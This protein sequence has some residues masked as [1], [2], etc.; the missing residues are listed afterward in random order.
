[1]DRPFRFS[2][3]DPR[4]WLRAETG[5][6]DVL[7]VPARRDPGTGPP[8]LEGIAEQAVE[9]GLLPLRPPPVFPFDPTR[10][11]LVATYAQKIGKCVVFSLA[12]FRQCYAAGRSLEDVDTLLI[13]A[14]AAEIHPRAVLQALERDAI[15]EALEAA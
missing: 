14:A 8:S 11:L 5:R 2:F 6:R 9:H 4:D 10:A 3:D 15:R 7:W 12:A 1:M 13:A